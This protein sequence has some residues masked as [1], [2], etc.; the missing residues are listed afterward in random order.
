M[1]CE[2]AQ[3]PYSALAPELCARIDRGM[4]QQAGH[5]AGWLDGGV[6][7]MYFVLCDPDD[8]DAIYQFG[9]PAAHARQVLSGQ[10]PLQQFRRPDLRH[11]AA[12]AAG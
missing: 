8:P 10:R 11:K 2:K 4:Y 5:L 6:S 7:A 12:S 1:C 9:L 3:K